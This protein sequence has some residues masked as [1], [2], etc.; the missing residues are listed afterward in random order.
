MNCYHCGCLLSEHDFCTACGADVSLYKRIMRISNMYYNEGLEK[1]GV[2]DLTGAVTCLRQSLKFNKNNVE[3]RNLLGL[4]YFE[5]GEVVAA[6]SEWVISKNLRPQK[7]VADVYIDM[8]QSN[9][10]RLDT[11]NQTIKKYNQALVYCMNDSKDLAVIQLKKVLS[12]NPKFIRAHQLLALLYIESEQWEKAKRELV[13][14]CNIDTNNTLTRRY[15]KEVEAILEPDETVKGDV[16][17]KKEEAVRYQSD[18][19]IIIQPLNVKEP[20]RSGVGTL[21]NVVIG[22]IIGMAAMYFLVVPAAVTEEKNKAND[23]ITQITALMDT[24]TS[25]IAEQEQ[26]IKDLQ[27]EIE[28]LELQIEGYV[29]ED[30]ALHTFD[31]LMDVAKEYLYTADAMAT[32]EYLEEVKAAVVFEETSQAFQEL[33]QAL[34]DTIGPQVSAT[35]YETGYEAYMDELY[36]RAIEDL[37]KAVEYD[38]TNRDALFNLANAYRKS[39]DKQNAIAT[40]E[41][42]IELFPDTQSAN[43]SQRYLNELNKE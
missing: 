2:R 8:I 23:Q 19:E 32:A 4:V 34:F 11:I 35:Y 26:K 20:K 9:A 25:T 13:K 14:C 42:V 43:R 5:M 30:G 10:T 15:L 1:A 41:K 36:D 31:G 12:L 37:K 24:K 6:L 16:K 40:Y 17:R 22:L 3:A 33:Y 38:A 7:N 29:G 39:E 18:N 21:L 27:A 28:R